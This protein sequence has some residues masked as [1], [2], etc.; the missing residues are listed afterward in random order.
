MAIIAD[1]C[2]TAPPSC[3]ASRPDALYHI[4]LLALCGGTIVLAFILSTR[5][6]TQVVLPLV[7]VP[8]PELCMSRRMFGV[9]CPG[10]GLTRSFIALAR[11]NVAAAWAFNPAGLLLFAVVAFQVPFRIWQL[12]RIRRGL[13]EIVLGRTAYMS[14]IAVTV[15]LVAQWALRLMGVPL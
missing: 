9:S 4:V 14:L 1:H 10:C 11:G 2:M 5:D 8:L 7:N 12:A 13:P 6:Q 15:L 3:R